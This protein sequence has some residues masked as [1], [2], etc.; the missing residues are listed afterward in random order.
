MG[1]VDEFDHLIA[2]EV[3]LDGKL[4]PPS[5]VYTVPNSSNI[6]KAVKA[7]RNTRIRR[8]SPHSSRTL[9]IPKNAD[10]HTL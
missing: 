1:A 8:K 4:R 7:I 6:P 10:F 2:Y 5:T 9:F 3:S